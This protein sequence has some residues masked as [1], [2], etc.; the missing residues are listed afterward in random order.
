MQQLTSVFSAGNTFARY[1]LNFW[2]G[3]LLVGFYCV[4]VGFFVFP[5]NS[6]IQSGFYS[7]VALPT[8]M[9]LIYQRPS[10]LNTKLFLLFLAAPIYLAVSSFWADP[11]VADTYR[12]PLFFLKLSLLLFL[13]FISIRLLFDRY[14]QFLEIWIYVFAIIGS[15]SAL[16]GL[17]DYIIEHHAVLPARFP[18]FKGV[19]WGGDTN[20]VAAFYGIGFLANLYLLNKGTLKFKIIAGLGLIPILMC[21]LLAQSKAPLVMLGLAVLGFSATGLKR[22]NYLWLGITLIIFSGIAAW[23]VFGNN[24][25]ARSYSFFIRGEIWSKALE[26]LGDQWFW[27]AG[28]NYRVNLIADGTTFGQA[29]NLLIDAM[30]FGG[31]VVVTL[32][33]A[34]ILCALYLYISRIQLTALNIFLLAWFL[35]GLAT[36]LVEAQQPLIRPSYI[37]LLYW[38]PLALIYQNSKFSR[39]ASDS[40]CRELE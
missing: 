21:I 2:F 28:L 24:T 20:R 33:S 8:A 34:Q 29:H 7:L 22:K 15:V 19:I 17:V 23:L 14:Q 38:I 10:Q 6:G 9:I 39:K 12:E 27:G 18:R 25:F 3:A 11:N 40:T 1:W 13:F 36:A 37:W 26:Q 31:V 5:S 32:L 35:T 16:V 4:T 30:R